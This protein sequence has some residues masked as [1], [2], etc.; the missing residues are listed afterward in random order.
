MSATEEERKRTAKVAVL[1][2]PEPVHERFVLTNKSGKLPVSK[3]VLE[4]HLKRTF[5]N[6]FSSRPMPDIER[7][8]RPTRPGIEFN[9]AEQD[10]EFEEVERFIMKA[11]SAAAPGSNGVLFK[12]YKKVG[13]SGSICRSR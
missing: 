4:K 7:L 10:Q 11:R 2:E 3:E 8:V 6:E 5:S 1:Q 9:V 12:V 13:S